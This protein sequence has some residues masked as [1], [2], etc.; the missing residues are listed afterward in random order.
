MKETISSDS[1][2]ARLDIPFACEQHARIAYNTLLVDSEPRK[3]LIRKSLAL[4]TSNKRVLTVEWTAKESRI[5][6]VSVNSFLDSLNSV[7]E[8]IQ[9]FD[10][11]N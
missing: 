5:L 10:T 1:L 2:R 11:A 6:R 8:T 7:L 3:E 4:D 9:L